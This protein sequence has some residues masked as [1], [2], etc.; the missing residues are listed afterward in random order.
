[1]AIRIAG[2]HEPESESLGSTR[3]IGESRPA[4]EAG[5]G[6]VAVDGVEMIEEPAS[7]QTGNLLGLE[8][9]VE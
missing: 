7:V 5:T 6:R 2:H 4:L 9:P 1:M 8:P 3:Q